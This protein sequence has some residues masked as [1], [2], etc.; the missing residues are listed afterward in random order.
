M[1]SVIDDCLD[2]DLDHSGGEEDFK[3]VKQEMQPVQKKKLQ[4]KDK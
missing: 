1:C 4:K 3:A 2:N